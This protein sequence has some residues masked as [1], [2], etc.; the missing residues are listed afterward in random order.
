MK[1]FMRKIFMSVSPAMAALVLVGGIIPLSAFEAHVVNIT[2]KIE[3]RPCI[4]FE[5]RSFGFWKN[6]EQSRI[7]PQTLGGEAIINDAEADAVFDLP[8]NIMVNKLKKQ[9]LS[10]KFNVSFYNSGTALVPGSTTTVN[11][12][13]TE[14]DNML[15]TDPLPS[16]SVLEA[17]KNKLESANTDGTLST[18]PKDEGGDNGEE[19]DDEEENGGNDN[20]NDNNE[21]EHA[22]NGNEN[23]NRGNDKKTGV[24]ASSESDTSA[25]TTATTTAPEITATSTVSN[26]SASSEPSA[27]TATTTPTETTASSETATSTTTSATTT[28]LTTEEETNDNNAPSATTTT[29]AAG[30]GNENPPAT[31]EET[32]PDTE[33]PPTESISTSPDAALKVE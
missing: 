30:T 14:A 26:S 25:T 12:L 24:T 6:F 29:E 28:S 7:Y 31:P 9:L 3:R 17:M 23:E 13:V 33:T 18:C 21:E 8:N 11:Q 4:E 15:L 10:L 2:A 16:D 27:T 32:T 1:N 19:G 20:E 22:N 5:T